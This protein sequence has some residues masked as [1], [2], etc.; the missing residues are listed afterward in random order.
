MSVSGRS[1]KTLDLAKRR[2]FFWQSYDLYGGLGGFID[3]GPLGALLKRKIEAKWIRHFVRSEGL[4]LIDTP[5][6]T[7]KAVFDSSGHTTHFTDPVTECLKCHRKWRADQLLEERTGASMESFSLAQLGGKIKEPGIAC[8]ECSGELDEPQL[9]N[10]LFVTT[11]GPYS[12]SVGFGRPETAQGI[13]VNFKR[14]NEL[15]RSRLPFGVAQIGK[16]V[17]NEIAPRQGPIRLRE[18]TIMEFEFFFDPSDPK[19]ES[20]DRVANRSLRIIPTKSAKQTTPETVLVRDAV[21]SGYLQSPWAA[22][23]MA[24]AEIFMNELG[25]PD[26]KQ[27]FIEKHPHERAHYSAQTFDQVVELERWGQ[28]EVSGHAWR[29]DYDLKTHM[30][31]TGTDLRV[32]VPYEKTKQLKKLTI[33]PQKKSLTET[34]GEKTSMISRLLDLA[35]PEEVQ[36]ALNRTGEYHVSSGGEKYV[37]TKELVD[38]REVESEETGRRFLPSVIEPSFGL[39]RIVYTVL[40]YAY[41][42]KEG[43]TIL[44]LPLEIA[45]IEVV[46]FPLVS[47]N[48]LPEFSHK[49]RNRLVED[50][51][52]AEYDDSGTIGRRYAR[53]DEIGVPIAVTID[54]QTMTD[55]TV[56][57]RDR[58]SWSQT[59]IPADN[60]LSYLQNFLNRAA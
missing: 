7:P 37:V 36:E 12:D 9:F 19:C 8:P 5:L 58:D 50:G 42:E 43:R 17:R 44:A 34:F 21:E 26:N 54:Y 53:A 14:L 51:L 1:E 38:F 46:V 13:F 35:S 41:T 6:I 60:L 55:N 4:M 48:G 30:A 49:L 16:C 22:Y 57:V 18:L 3:Y 28:V 52:V 40:E 20:L 31:Q 39:D 23:F 59:R 24:R 32:F 27:F 45:P 2:G 33:I 15:A 10:E 11:I 56:T 47:K 25:V 29:T